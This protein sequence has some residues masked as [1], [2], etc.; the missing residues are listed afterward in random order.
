M[1]LNCK[2]DDVAW[3]KAAAGPNVGRFVTCVRLIP[4]Q[5]WHHA[6]GTSSRAPTWE[7][8]SDIQAWDGAR[9]RFCPDAYLQPISRPGSDG[10]D[11]HDILYDS[12]AAA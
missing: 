1:K 9:H 7:L 8:D 3:I 6:D 5:L 4:N 11:E 10:I 2:Q 12:W